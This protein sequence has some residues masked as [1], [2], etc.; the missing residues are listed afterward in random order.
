[1]KRRMFFCFLLLFIFLTGCGM[2]AKK[3]QGTYQIYYLDKN[4]SHIAGTDYEAEASPEDKEAMVEELLFRLASPADKVDYRPAIQKF[5]VLHY[6]FLEEQ[7]TLNLSQEYKNLE[8]IEEVLTRA[9]LV[10]TLTQLEGISYVTIQINGENLMD[11]SGMTVGVMTADTFIDNTGEEMKNYEETELILYFAN[12]T[13]DRLVKVNRTLVYNTNISKEKLVVEQLIKGP[14]NQKEPMVEGIQPTINPQT[15][16]LSVNVK[17]GI[18]YVNLDDSFLTSVY[19]VNTDT[20]IYSLVNSLTE[21]SGVIKVQIA[22][23]GETK[24]IYQE[25]YDLSAPFEAKPELVQPADST[26]GEG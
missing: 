16:I 7:I 19:T 8:P 26:E 22:I 1:M 24:I 20:I 2:T 14:L 25:K 17:D 15:Q 23:E 13:G 3:E 4:N 18:C 5:S 10:K 9:A 6:T 21:L 12:I 11:N